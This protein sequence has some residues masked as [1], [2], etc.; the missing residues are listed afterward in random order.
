MEAPDSAPAEV[1]RRV[2]VFAR[3][4]VNLVVATMMLLLPA[5]LFSLRFRWRHVFPRYIEFWRS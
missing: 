5:G 1:N 4:P 3:L 2:L